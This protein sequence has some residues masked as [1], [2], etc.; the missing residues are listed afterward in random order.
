MF[1]LPL[2]ALERLLRTSASQGEVDGVTALLDT[3][4]RVDAEDQEG[5]T[6]LY[7]AAREGWLDT[8][9]LLLAR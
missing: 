9:K 4:V 8:V 2:Q 6:P 1:Y 5:Q 7:L 3:G